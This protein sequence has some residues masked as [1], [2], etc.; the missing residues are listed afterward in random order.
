MHPGTCERVAHCIKSGSSKEGG[1][2]SD[3]T[4]ALHE[5]S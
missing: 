2:A 4:K 3:G 5:I 1:A